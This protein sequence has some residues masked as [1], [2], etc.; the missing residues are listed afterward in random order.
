M[1][2]VDRD[3]KSKLK[4]ALSLEEFCDTAALRRGYGRKQLRRPRQV[5]L[6]HSRLVL[7]NHKR[8]RKCEDVHVLVR[9]KHA[10]VL[11]QVAKHIE[12]AG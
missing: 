9:R 12:F 2:S 1:V 8:E 11:G 6:Q 3:A 10:V 4:H 5:A 7:N